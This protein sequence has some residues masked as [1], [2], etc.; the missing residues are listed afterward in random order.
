M[1]VGRRLGDE[2]GAD[3]AVRTGLVLDDD[4]LPERLRQS[5]SDRARKNVGCSS[6]RIGND[7]ADRLR[8]IR[9]R[10]RRNRDC[11]NGSDQNR[12]DK[13]KHRNLPLTNERQNTDDATNDASLPLDFRCRVGDDRCVRRYSA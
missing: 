10:V 7:D 2:I 4:R 9:L 3:V 8:R 5:L 13:A 11:E 12:G 6:G 1:T